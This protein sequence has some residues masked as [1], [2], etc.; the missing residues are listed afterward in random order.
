MTPSMHT[1]RRSGRFRR[2]ASGLAAAV[3]ALC[4]TFLGTG[5]AYADAY[6]YWGFHQAKD[7]DW[8]FSDKGPA[9]VTPKDGD[10]DGWRYAIAGES[11]GQRVPRTDVTFDEL[12][13]DTPKPAG[14]K[15]VGIVLDYGLEGEAPDGD[16]P[17]PARGECAVVGA[18]ATS[19]QVLA[20]V[21]Q[22]RE[23]K[24]LVCA[25]DAFP[26]AGCG[27]PVAD[28]PKVPSPEPSVELLLPSGDPTPAAGDGKDEPAGEVH[29]VSE[30]AS[31]GGFPV[32][33]VVGAAVLVLL[34]AGGLWQYNRRRG[35]DAS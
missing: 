1:E 32:L 26:S 18:D 25:I 5:T 34:I 9:Q 30:R 23:D 7:G 11:T 33:P 22:V 24:G 31:D 20:E 35:S 27:D 13:G 15:R 16:A 4:V 12:C 10:V 17:P 29:A 14:Q 2:Y 19:A 8:A 3:I 21:A 28:E 6:R